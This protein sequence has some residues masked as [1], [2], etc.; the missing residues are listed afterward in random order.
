VSNS[1]D[2]PPAVGFAPFVALKIPM[3]QAARRGGRFALLSDWE[4]M[5]H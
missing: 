4:F 2:R 1:P 5:I 3:S